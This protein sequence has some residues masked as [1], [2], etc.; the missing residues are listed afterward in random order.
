MG[1]VIT[2]KSQQAESTYKT[3]VLPL[4]SG[5]HSKLRLLGKTQSELGQMPFPDLSTAAGH[6]GVNLWVWHSRD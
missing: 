2:F 3:Q 6:G 4:V 5:L 1:M